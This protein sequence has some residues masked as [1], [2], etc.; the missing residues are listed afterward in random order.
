MEG[1]RR[2]LSDEEVS[3]QFVIFMT[4]GFESIAIT[5]SHMAYV[6]ATDP[7]IQEKL[8]EELDN[9][10]KTRGDMPLCDFV[11]SL[12][13]LDQPICEVLSL[14]TPRFNNSRRSHVHVHHKWY[15]NSTWCIRVH[16][17]VCTPPGPCVMA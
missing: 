13:Y 17:S 15:H 1:V 9:A 5:L 2:K 7:E 4:A 16:P 14:Y 3:P 10:I 11:N 12:D 6:L 8:H